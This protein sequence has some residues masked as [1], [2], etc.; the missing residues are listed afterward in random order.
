MSGEVH[1][2][3]PDQHDIILFGV[4]MSGFG[5][6]TMCTFEED[7]DTFTVVEGVD[8]DFTRSKR[9][10]KK[11][12]LVVS[13]M[14]SSRS[15]DILSGVYNQD[16]AQPGGAGV[17][18]CMVR[19]RNGTSVLATDKC[20]IIKAPPITRSRQAVALEWRIQV[21]GYA[22]HVGGTT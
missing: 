14:S 21:L 5:P 20:Y 16:R 18:P 1:E 3:D 15:N 10:G 12:T 4:P 6:D 11:G 8:G 17:G 22:L 13:L 9:I 2:F 7:E 19:D